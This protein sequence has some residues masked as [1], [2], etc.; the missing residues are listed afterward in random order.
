MITITAIIRVKP[1][2]EAGMRSAL[3]GVAS[4]VQD[5][6]P[7]TVG[8]F[9]SNSIAQPHVFTTYERFADRAAMEAHNNA[10]IVHRLLEIAQPMLDGP[11]VLEIGEEIFAKDG[12]TSPA[13]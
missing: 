6:E 12:V 10:E 11:I 7:D 2:T 13:T 8:Y 1:G 5:R 9:I 3:E 4:Y